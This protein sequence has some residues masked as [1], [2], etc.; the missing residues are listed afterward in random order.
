MGESR[1]R[2]G[3][4][5][6]LHFT[7]YYEDARGHRRPAGTFTSLNPIQRLIADRRGIPDYRR[8]QAWQP[9]R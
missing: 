5:G 7:A 1:R 4:D 2:V 9:A 3:R 8:R 6:R